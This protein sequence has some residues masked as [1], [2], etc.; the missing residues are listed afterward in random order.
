M[1]LDL[2]DFEGSPKIIGLWATRGAGCEKYAETTEKA[3]TA[4]GVQFEFRNLAKR[5]FE[6]IKHA[7]LTINEDVLLHGL[8]LYLPILGPDKVGLLFCEYC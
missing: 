2:A 8:I 5:D 1:A 7:I 3:C 6:T 4:N